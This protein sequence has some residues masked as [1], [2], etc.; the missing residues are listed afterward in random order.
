MSK[1][2]V[3]ARD[4]KE[5]CSLLGLPA[6]YAPKAAMRR[7]LVLAIRDVLEE[8]N[9][10]HEAAGI[11]CDVGRTVITSIANGSIEK[12][13]TDRLIHVADALGLDV[14]LK[15]AMK[16]KPSRKAQ[17]KAQATNRSRRSAAH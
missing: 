10:T 14:S 3:E 1:A 11:L 4:L 9:L 5:L 2:Y 17:S 7:D 8:R 13:S 12:I 6:S 15:I 16:A